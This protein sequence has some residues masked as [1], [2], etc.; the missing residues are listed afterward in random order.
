MERGKKTG[1]ILRQF[2]KKS[3]RIVNKDIFTEFFYINRQRRVIEFLTNDD[4]LV[5]NN[6]MRE[7]LPAEFRTFVSIK[8]LNDVEEE[9]KTWYYDDE[10]LVIV[11]EINWGF[12]KQEISVDLDIENFVVTVIDENGVATRDIDYFLFNDYV[13]SFI[14]LQARSLAESFAML[15]KKK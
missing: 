3:K 6:F 14:T 1:F 12:K 7:F 2:K 9:I 10:T 13:I 5:M 11:I 15:S 8:I 4:I